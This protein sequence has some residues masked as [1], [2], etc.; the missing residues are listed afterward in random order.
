MLRTTDKAVRHCAMAAILTF[1]LLLTV[2][3]IAVAGQCISGDGCTYLTIEKPSNCIVLRNSSSTAIKYAG[4]VAFSPTGMVYGNSSVTPVS[5]QGQCFPDFPWDYTAYL[6]GDVS[7][8]G[9]NKVRNMRELGYGGGNKGKFCNSKGYEGNTNFDGTR[10]YDNGGGWCYSGDR[11][12]CLAQ[13][14]GK[15]SH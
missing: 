4:T 13:V 1:G 2:S 3:A 12:A 15:G 10:Y 8:G 7:G 5:L 9:C 11:L 14:R 6:M